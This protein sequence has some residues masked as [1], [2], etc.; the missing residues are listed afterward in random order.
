MSEMRTEEE[1]IEA[2]KNWWKENGKQTA[3]AVVVVAASWFGFQGYQD[4]Q[5]TTGEAASAIYQQ[6]LTINNSEVEADKGRR[7]LLLDQLT[8]EYKDTVYAQY[9]ALFNAK[10]AVDGDDLALAQ[11]QLRSVIDN[12]KDESL[13]QL[14]TVRLARV[15][16]AMEKTDEALALVET[17]PSAAF[18][19]EFEE[20]KGDIYFATGEKD[21]ARDAY[22]KAVAAAQRIG[23][24]NPVLKMKLDDLAVSN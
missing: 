12:A 18:E 2:I 17:S 10:D 20:T 5:K 24:N 13:T 4:Q 7:S 21:S 19:A 8:G 14:A 16:L 22:S 15:L 11:T 6:V 3:V 9:A 1:Q 23:G